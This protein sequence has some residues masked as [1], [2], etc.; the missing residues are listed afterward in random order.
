MA[1]LLNVG[2]KIR[3]WLFRELAPKFPSE[4]GAMSLTPLPP[5]KCTSGTFCLPIGHKWSLTCLAKILGEH[6]KNAHVKLKREGEKRETKDH[7]K[8][9]GRGI[10]GKWISSP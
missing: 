9:F 7:C 10:V 1:D 2:L 8:I 4:G 5:G 6:C 3:E